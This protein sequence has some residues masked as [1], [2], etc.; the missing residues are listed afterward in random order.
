MSQEANSKQR[1]A[2]DQTVNQPGTAAKVPTVTYD[3]SCRNLPAPKPISHPRPVHRRRLRSKVLLVVMLLGAVG[4]TY[5]W[6]Q[7]QVQ[8]PASIVW[9][10]GRIDSDEIEI[11]TKY[12]GRIVEMFAEKRHGQSGASRGAHGHPG[13]PGVAEE[14]GG[15]GPPRTEGRGRSQVQCR[16]A[17]EQFAAGT[18]NRNF[19]WVAQLD[20]VGQRYGAAVALDEVTIDLPGSCMVGLIG[21]DGVGKSS[22]PSIV[23][24]SR[25]IQSGKVFVLDGDMADATHRAAIC[26]RIAYMPQGLGRNLYPDLSVRENIEFFGRLFGQSRWRMA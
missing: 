22:L 11:D 5:W 15:S 2:G 19:S 14:G 7:H 25:Q 3:T 10:N 9:S 8:V 1:A 4:G 17:D 12:A 16:P 26:P 18:V 6:K 13:Y 21:P 24:G 20:H 23:A